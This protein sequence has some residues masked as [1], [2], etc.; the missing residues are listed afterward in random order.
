MRSNSSDEDDDD[1]PKD[2]V[3]GVTAEDLAR[4]RN[5]AR[6]Y[7]DP[8]EFAANLDRLTRMH[9]LTR[10]EVAKQIGAPYQWYRRVVTKGLVRISKENRVYLEALVDLFRLGRIED[11]WR[12]DLIRFDV[13][14][15]GLDPEAD[16][17]TQLAWRQRELWPYAEKLGRL[18]ASGKHEYLK[19]LIDRLH[20]TLP[21]DV[22]EPPP[23]A[24]HWSSG[25]ADEEED[26]ESEA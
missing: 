8:D 15:P 22:P 16:Q 20:E 1:R 26:E 13:E 17:H 19:D 7:Q 5:K 3:H 23:M 10:K 18:L 21:K 6:D 11:L 9:G 4:V 14:T 2:K 24:Q 25:D 12:P